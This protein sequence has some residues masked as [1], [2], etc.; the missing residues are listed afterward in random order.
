MKLIDCYVSAFGKLKDFS[1]TFGGGLNTVKEENGWG[2]STFATFIKAMFYGLDDA[3]RT[4]DD[5]E[6]KKYAPWNSTEK[7]GGSLTFEW[8][9]K[10]FKIERFFGAKASD[11]TVKLYDLASGKEFTEGAGA[12]NLGKRVFG[13]DEEGF[14]STTYFSQKDFEIKSNTSITAKFNEVCE[15]QDS[16]AFDK[17][18]DKLDEK[19]KSLKARGDKGRIYELKRKI[20]ETDDVIER[21]RRA[22]S[23][24]EALAGERDA[25]IA[26]RDELAA[27][28]K[29]LTEKIEKAGKRE[30][31]AE[32][33][34]RSAALKAELAAVK[35]KKTAFDG[36]L[37]GKNLTAAQINDCEKCVND[38]YDVS[39]KV[40]MLKDDIAD[41]TEEFSPK[42]AVKLTKRQK[43][44]NIFIQVFAALMCVA[45]IIVS[46]AV[47]LWGLIL[48]CAGVVAG[49]LAMGK[50]DNAELTEVYERKKRE[51]AATEDC[52]TQLEN[53]LNE[54]FSRFDFGGETPDF[55][56]RLNIVKD[57]VKESA[58]CAERIAKLTEEINA[59]AAVGATDGETEGGESVAELNDKLKTATEWYGEKVKQIER[60]NS[61]IESLDETADSL[62]YSETAKNELKEEL[63][64]CEKEL[65]ILVKTVEF[66][67]AADESLKIKYR[68]PL[69]G[70]LNKYLKLISGAELSAVIDTDMKVS[71]Q[72]G[73]AARDTE[74]FSKGYRNLFE[75]CKR[76]SLTDV[77]FTGEKPFMILDDP[78][79]NLDDEK[80]IAAISLIRNLS[81]EYQI[82][83]FVCHGSRA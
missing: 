8:G 76:F 46:V 69:Q 62:V 47:H 60:V 41:I 66:M 14:L 39:T 29:S 58:A 18:L 32:R 71:V 13:I 56:Q 68:A 65:K 23:S 30:A 9:G 57:A 48:L 73:G 59:I 40:D 35:E 1:Y 4:V 53:G 79:C 64:A 81:D 52:K 22:V 10:K 44:L 3:K 7:F 75:I 38:F 25:L 61:R 45:G 20:T 31:F 37:N 12:E 28:I 74:F 2:K 17:A 36:T 67:K 49:F 51:L 33:A 5:N 55:R 54:F 72:I 19:I 27:G 50:R 24:A 83:Y 6:R 82:L 78:F 63:A 21:N 15:V 26:D 80:V 11:D 34:K 16:D 70:S 77:L 42:K 43:R